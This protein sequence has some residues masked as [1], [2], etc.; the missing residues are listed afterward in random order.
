M[1][2]TGKILRPVTSL[3]IPLGCT[4]LHACMRAASKAGTVSIQHFPSLCKEGSVE[5]EKL[6]GTWQLDRKA[7]ISTSGAWLRKQSC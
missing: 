5:K 1:S 6:E 4:R 2:L 3:L 7:V